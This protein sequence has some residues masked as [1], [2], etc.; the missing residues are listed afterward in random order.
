[1]RRFLTLFTML[2][3]CGVL[4]FA[5]TRVVSGRVTDRDGNAVPFASIKIKG[6]PTG[7]SAD[8]NGAYTIRIKDGDVLEVSGTSFKPVDVPV[9]TQ[10]SITTMLEKNTAVNDL[11]EIVVTGAFNTKRTAR[12]TV[13]NAQN[14]TGD[15][16]NTIRQPNINNAL[17][18]KVAGLQ[19][20]SQSAASLGADNI[21]RLRGENGIGIGG[22]AL[23]VVDG[24]IMPSANDISTDDVE[25]VT[26]LQGPAAAALFGSD[27]ANG[28]IIVTTKK[29]KRNQPGIGL[30]INSGVQFDRVYIL[31]DY[32]NAYAG[33]TDG[34][35][36]QYHYKAG[37]PEGWK[38]LDGKYYHDY[39]EDVSWGPRMAGQEYIPWYAWY[40]GSEYSYKTAKLTPQPN[41]VRDFFNTGVTKN[42]NINFSKAGEGYNIRASYTNLDQQG[43]IP[44]S[45]LK[46]HTFTVNASID[47][48]SKFTVAVNAN[49][50]SQR[51]NSENDNTYGNTTSGSFNQWFHRD[52]E[53]SKL[54]ELRYLRGP[55][56]ELTTWN[57]NNPESY[58]VSNNGSSFFK[59]YYWHGP[60]TWQDNVLNFTNRDRLFGDA[61][62]T[63]KPT[64]DLTFK[65]T[66]RK[67]QLTTNSDTRMYNAL[68]LSAGT[69]S[70]FNYW[71]A[72][73]GRSRVW[74]GYGL[75]YSQ[76][77]RQNYEF[78]GTYRKKIKNF[79]FNLLGGIDLLKTR[80]SSYNANT[81]G[82][83][84]V[85]D[86]FSLSN[87]KNGVNQANT[88][89]NTARRALFANLS[90]GYK[91]F[92]FVEGTYRRDYSS[93]ERQG[94]YI[95]T[96]S[97][98]A[99]F[100]FSDLINKNGSTFLSFGKIR[101]SIGQILNTLGA[102]QYSTYT[103]N[104]LL[105]GNNLLMGE[106]NTLFDPLLHGAAQ[107]E[108]EAGI[109]LRFLKNRIGI[110]ATYW[111][112]TN[113]DFPL[114]VGVSPYTGYNT[115]NTNAGEVKK[116]GIDI[117]LFLNPI[118]SK[119]FD[120]TLNGT[121]GRLL[122][123]DV[124]SINDELNIQRITT[125]A[126][127]NGNINLVSEKGQRWGQLR[128]TAIK[129]INGQ[130]VLRTDGIYEREQN[131]NF[132]SSLPD[133]TGGVQNTFT[134]FKNFLVN[135]NVDFSYGGK[136]FS[137]SDWYGSGTGL[138]ARTAGMNDRGIPIRDAV[139]DG[140]GIH[141]F[142]VDGT[143]KAVDY[144]VEAR[145]YFEQ[146]GL[147]SQGIVE[148]S[149]RDL[150]FVKLREFSL[151]YKVPV[152]KLGIGKYVKNAVFS[153]VA[154]NPWL[155][156]SKG[157][158]FDPSE[159]SNN[160]GEDGQFP[161]TRSLGFNLKLGF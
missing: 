107:T 139:A 54:K 90:I 25:D 31:P 159:L 146:N 125:E 160:S 23:Y 147:Y 70:G 97:V 65:F 133:Y 155:I 35:F 153:V 78:L 46:K 69:N 103:P 132:G 67:Q 56:G 40:S 105:W 9:G 89:T 6:T 118:R 154:R 124:I 108:K 37:D 55:N 12:S 61:S 106:P 110:T 129:R 44:N 52:L 59:A 39:T 57:H 85:P 87:G 114:S 142:G 115:V 11:K 66:Y 51:S 95:E 84:F 151:G 24:T 41:N 50:I 136:F 119:N 150:T 71:E 19:V 34:N 109:E 161:G 82:G 83:L 7:I 21:V 127:G 116:T 33:G 94:Y 117:Q 36:R 148:E 49:Y 128:G 2:M 123:N 48:S 73:N 122:K 86:F 75:G 20:R 91:N 100:V 14:V 104:T 74:G 157:K 27:G 92:A 68:D 8:A 135:I 141:V 76:S 121:W 149:L 13:A 63:Y 158:G 80:L 143:G 101:G 98:G 5:Q 156:Y 60:Y 134:L 15:Q 144:Y 45:Y 28:A 111:D 32:Q 72:A 138:T 47:L 93:T 81:L 126:G 22:G 38:Q 42:N 130:P 112:R 16:M 30:E 4:A 145:D 1:M 29:A 96:K 18:G 43:L 152:S 3:L 58:S 10:T 17:A 99:S 26:V 137:L 88:I 79:Q 62:L 140:G 113:K 53:I 102:Y 77:N 120:W 64:N 131:V